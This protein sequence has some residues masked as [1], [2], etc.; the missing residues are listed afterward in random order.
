[1]ID[2]EISGLSIRNFFGG[3]LDVHVLVKI[4]CIFHRKTH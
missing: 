3:Y 4:V 2:T 1:M